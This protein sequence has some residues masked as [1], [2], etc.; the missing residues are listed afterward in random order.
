VM[1][2]IAAEAAQDPD[3]LHNAPHNT[4]ISRPDE[5]AAARNPILKYWDACD[6]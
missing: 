6:C 2:K 1:R 4:P 5:T 3:I